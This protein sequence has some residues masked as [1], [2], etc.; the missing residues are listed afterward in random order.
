V[1]SVPQ[2]TQ[3]PYS[4]FSMSSKE[5]RIFLISMLSRSRIRSAVLLSDSKVAQSRKSAEIASTFNSR[6]DV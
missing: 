4:P 2:S 3:M 1:I 5:L 6:F